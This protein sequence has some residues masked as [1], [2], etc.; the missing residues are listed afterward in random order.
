MKKLIQI[1]ICA[2]IEAGKAIIEIY[3]TGFD[4]ELKEDN[5]PLTTA[6][7]KAHKI[8]SEYLI[9]TGIPIL[10][11]E[12]KQLAYE[13]RKQWHQFWLVDPL[14]GTKE[15]IKKNGEFTVNIAFIEDG[16]TVAGV[17][18]VPVTDILYVGLKNKGAF[19]LD[20]TSGFDGSVDQLIKTAA[21]LPENKADDEYI[22]VASRSHLNS[23]T[24]LF[25]EKSKKIHPN[26]KIVSKGS[27]LKLCLV[28]EG[29]ADV[30]PRFAPTM[31][32]DIAAGHAIVN[33]SGGQVLLAEDEKTELKYNK[34]NLLNPW[35]IAE[36]RRY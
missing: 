7:K 10:S 4:I 26:I 28:A 16:K 5:S 11:E 14:D 31:E 35:F 15:F 6:D 23:E 34:E 25:L 24:A 30:Y 13:E 21:K 17:I 3:N 12:G 29:K 36:R 33:A 9:D 27:S 18:Y 20:D 19:K 32:W 22:V 8:I 2:A 1:A